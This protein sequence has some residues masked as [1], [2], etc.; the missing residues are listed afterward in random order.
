M[1]T[2]RHHP[3]SASAPLRLLLLIVA[4]L[5]PIFL[6]AQEPAAPPDTAARPIDSVAMQESTSHSIFRRIGDDFIRQAGSPFRA[7]EGDWLRVG[8]AAAAVGMLISNDGAIDQTMRDLRDHSAAVN[9]ASP[10]VTELGGSYGYIGS[11]LFIG[12]SFLFDDRK[13]KETSILLTEA[14]VTSGVWAQVF[15]YAAG[16]ERPS[17]A[18]DHPHRYG[19][20]WYGP[21]ERFSNPDHLSSASFSSFPSGHTTTAFAIATVFAEQYDG[22]PVVPIIAYTAASLVGA[23]RMTEH[24]HWASDVVAGALL[25]YF[26]AHDVVAGHRRTSGRISDASPT[27]EIDYRLSFGAVGDG[28]GMGIA[29]R[30]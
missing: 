12:Y 2:R 29:L 4:F 16:R 17:V 14:L 1:I 10:Y 30:F 23:S 11:A 22:T 7:D 18:F 24:A 21:L 25:G 19:G 5:F 6:A 9:S 26:C 13:G 28:L 20:R 8:G 15:K 3:R 27:G